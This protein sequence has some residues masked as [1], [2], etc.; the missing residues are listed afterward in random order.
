MDPAPQEK[1]KDQVQEKHSEGGIGQGINVINNL[2]GGGIKNP[3]GKIGSK[4]ASQT[5]LRGF[6]AF[7]ASPAGLPILIAIALVVV[8]TVIV[9]GFGGVPAIEPTR[10]Q[11]PTPTPLA[12]P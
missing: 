10:I 11:A 6:A 2:M 7:L 1:Q 8:F 3:F 12:V 4:V 9:M 5:A